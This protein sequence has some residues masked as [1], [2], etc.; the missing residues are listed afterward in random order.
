MF[1]VYKKGGVK[2]SKTISFPE[3]DFGR[4]IMQLST[5]CVRD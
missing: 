5:F 3:H 1:L 4:S 2:G